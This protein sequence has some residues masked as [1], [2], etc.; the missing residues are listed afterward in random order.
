MMAAKTAKPRKRSSPVVAE[1]RVTDPAQ[2]FGATIIPFDHMGKDQRY[3]PKF[4]RRMILQYYYGIVADAIRLN[5]SVAARTP[6]RLYLNKQYNRPGYHTRKVSRSTRKYLCGDYP[7]YESMTFGGT[8]RLQVNNAPL[9]SNARKA[10]EWRDDLEEVSDPSHPV[11]R[12]LGSYSDTL[13]RFIQLQISG[14]I[15][16]TCYHDSITGNP[17]ELFTLKSHRV[18]P[19]PSTDDEPKQLLR[20][21]MYGK[22]ITSERFFRVEEIGHARFPHPDD[23]YVGMG[24]IEANYPYIKMAESQDLMDLA[25]FENNCRMEGIL[26]LDGAIQERE[27]ERFREQLMSEHKGPSNAGKMMVTKGA[28]V[29]WIPIQFNPKDMAG[30]QELFEKLIFGL[31]L[32]LTM[33][34]STESNY[35]NFSQGEQSYLDRTIAPMLRIDEELLNSWVLNQ[36]S[37]ENGLPLGDVAFLAYDNPVGEDKLAAANLRIAMTNSGQMTI[38]T[39]NTEVGL[40]PVEG[41]DIPRYN[42]VPLDKIGQSSEANPV[43]QYSLSGT[44]MQ[45]IKSIEPDNTPSS[46]TI[47]DVMSVM[48]QMSDSMRELTGKINHLIETDQQVH[49]EMDDKDKT[50]PCKV[51]EPIAKSE[52]AVDEP[53]LSDGQPPPMTDQER[54]LQSIFRDFLADCRQ[55]AIDSIVDIPTKAWLPDG[56]SEAIRKLVAQLR[57]EVKDIIGNVLA[58]GAVD[59]LS[60]ISISPSVFDVTNPSVIDFID[61]YVIRLTGD[62]GD[63]VITDLGRVISAGLE[64]GDSI[65][66]MAKR[67]EQSPGFDEQGITDRAEMIARTES[68]RATSAGQLQGWRESGVVQGKRWLLAPQHCPI[69]TIVAERCNTGNFGIDDAIFKKG[70]VITLPDG[71]IYAFDYEPIVFPPAHP[72]CRCSMTAVL[73]DREARND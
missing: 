73:K 67:I 22:L 4:D 12:L 30:R 62:L 72:N 31:G 47:S 26:A 7:I 13:D 69:C 44:A 29:T 59:A 57:G 63:Q 43:S 55:A 25:L 15:F 9:T 8:H 11:L 21:W 54:E 49:D 1:K 34:K 28:K 3:W 65:S 66:E 52:K 17:V 68:S 16:A 37:L 39:A 45:P 71:G 41:G 51:D 27:S 19:L 50:E 53:V 35:S 64:S 70:E 42:G 6:L 20:G 36:Y 48:L 24:L 23:D 38:N 56:L 60:E 18:W 5:A 46:I 58:A 33:I 2:I 40:P 10:M 32:S 14:D 61:N